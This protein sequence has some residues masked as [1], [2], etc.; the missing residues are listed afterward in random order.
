M[1]SITPSSLV[2]PSDRPL[3]AHLP[4]FG[5]SEN[6]WF[7]CVNSTWVIGLPPPLIGPAVGKGEIARWYPPASG[8]RAKYAKNRGGLNFTPVIHLSQGAGEAHYR[9]SQET[10]SFA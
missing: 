6:Y 5:Y 9:G 10:P 2:V 8:L 4:E 7:L 1:P 3:K